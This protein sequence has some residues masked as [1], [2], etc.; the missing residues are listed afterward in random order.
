MA[1]YVMYGFD[2]AGSLA[3]ETT[4]PRRKAPRAI[5]RALAAAAGAGGLL[6]LFA[7]LAAPELGDVKLADGDEGGLPLL[8]R[9]VLGEGVGKVLLCDV[10]F[11]VTVCTLAVHTG[12]VRMMFAMARDNNL[13]FGHSLSHV[14]QTSRTPIVPAVAAGLLAA[15]VLLVNVWLP[16]AVD[17]VAPVAIL[18]ANLAYLLVTLPLLVRRLRGWPGNA[19]PDGRPVFALGR[20]GVG[21]NLV[22]VVWGVGM[23]VNIGWPRRPTP[24]TTWYQ[25]YGAIL[26]TAALVA[27]GG[28]YYALVQRHKTGILE[29]HRA[30]GP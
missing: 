16:G 18:W 22:A 9:G 1:S 14:S 29:E 24:E 6:L 15:A 5:L 30:R 4:D 17:L 25:Q 26:F 20:W 19:R 2:T 28:L 23:I 21:V 7:L 12:A 27:V 10:I 3:E 8:V 13:P 11:A